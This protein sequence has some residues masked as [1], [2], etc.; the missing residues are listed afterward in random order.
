MIKV[1]KPL[2]ESDVY[3]AFN[4]IDCLAASKFKATITTIL[5]LCVLSNTVYSFR[6]LFLSVDVLKVLQNC[7]LMSS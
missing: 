2:I 4:L 1:T 5:H 3:D 7:K 6:I